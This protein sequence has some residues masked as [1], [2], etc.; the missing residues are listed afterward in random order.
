MNLKKIFPSLLFM[1]SINSYAMQYI[2]ADLE[3]FEKTGKCI[4]CDLSEVGLNSHDNADLSNALLIRANL[5]Y[6]HLYASNFS[7]AQMMYANLDNLKA[8]GSN[9][10]SANLTGASLR[11]VN[12][13]SC[14]LTAVNFT[15]ADLSYADL[16]RANVNIDQLA[17]AKSLHCTIMPD[18]SRHA[19]DQ[20]KSC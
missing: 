11:S 3:Q 6:I 2:P 4:G 9:F 17:T 8:S 1:F 14:N 5:A 12:F 10:E 20:G 19:P 15:N 16:A 18:G 7:H 13:S